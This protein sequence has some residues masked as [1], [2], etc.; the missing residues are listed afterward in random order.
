MLAVGAV[1]Q[2]YFCVVQVSY[3]QFEAMYKSE[4]DGINDDGYFALLLHN[5]WKSNH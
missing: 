4:S 2:I 1:L 3:E 5:E